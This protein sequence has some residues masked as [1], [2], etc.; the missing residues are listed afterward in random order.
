MADIIII[1]NSRSRNRGAPKVDLTPMVDLGFLLITFFMFTTSLSDPRA[2]QL[3]MP[4]R[5]PTS[6]P[7]AFAE[8]STITLLP[9][10]NDSIAYYLG[11]VDVKAGLK[12]CT[13]TELR[14]LLIREQ[15]RVSKLPSTYSKDAHGL[16]VL[17]KPQSN[18][19]YSTLVSVLDEMAI[20]SVPTYCIVDNSSADNV[21]L[22]K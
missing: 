15:D 8:S 17:I 5:T 13:Q 22:G 1:G 7:T 6:A 21:L 9:T 10:A 18:C 3:N 2:M 16:H 19:A 20:L 4:D 14:D 11:A 12:W